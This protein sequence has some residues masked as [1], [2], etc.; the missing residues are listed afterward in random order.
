MIY[1]FG[2]C[3]LNTQTAALRRSGQLISIEPQT[4]QLL[5]YLIEN[6]DR[7]VSKD[8][9]LERIWPGKVVSDASIANAVKVLRQALGDSARQQRYIRTQ[10]GHGYRWLIDAS[11]TQ[12]DPPEESWNEQHFP[13]LPDRPSVALLGF[14]SL[15][16]PGTTEVFAEGLAADLNTQLARLHGLFVIARDS[17]RKFTPASKSVAEIGQ[18][19]GVRY[20]LYGSIQKHG[21]RLRI[22]ISLAETFHDQ[23]I[24]AERFD[25][26]LDDLFAVQDEIVSAVVAK[27]LPEIERAEMDRARLLPT[28]NLDAWE[29]YHRAMW[30]N[31]RFT[32]QDSTM[33][34]QLL[35]QALS[36]DPLFARA[37]AGLSFNYFLHTFLNTSDQVEEHAQLA[38]EHAQ[39]SVSLDVRDAMSHWVLGRAQ[40][41]SRDH[42]AALFSLD[43]AL[44]ANP[45][46]AQ[47]RYARG[48]VGMHAGRATEAI[49][50]LDLARRLSP[51]DPLLFAMKS[52]RAVSLAIQGNLPDAV[53]W[54]VEATA[55]P[56]AHFHI[57]AIAA[58]CLQLNGQSEQA[59]A[60]TQRVLTMHPNY[61]IT[62]FE[63]SFPHRETAPRKLFRQALA[64]TGLTMKT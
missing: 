41:L 53:R 35:E 7:I 59:R 27:V 61:T 60:A 42:D 24:W 30:H 31:F 64:D 55:E 26:N 16:D 58:A 12:P 8:E 14:E 51:F 1:S 22:Q 32:A 37:H 3:D 28:E 56:H 47:G 5:L 9:L 45:N 17:A 49:P 15:G 62:V 11:R 21:S 23:V 44:Q 33:A 52:S 38:L 29:C 57:H 25:R 46:Y 20:V 54:A 50:D 40:F 63:R 39:N 19:L 48:F 10:R 18:L 4:Y 13:E 2:D 34:Q 6:P 43:R 36:L